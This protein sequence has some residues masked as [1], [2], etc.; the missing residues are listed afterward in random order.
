MKPMHEV[1]IE[2]RLSSK[3][4]ISSIQPCVTW[5]TGRKWILSAFWTIAPEISSKSLRF[6]VHV[7]DAA[8]S[9]NAKLSIELISWHDI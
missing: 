2:D 6:C 1:Q 4:K 5:A 9:P 3:L 7:A 8:H